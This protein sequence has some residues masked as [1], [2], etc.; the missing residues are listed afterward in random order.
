MAGV[1]K[2]DF[3]IKNLYK[4]TD[5]RDISFNEFNA[6]RAALRLVFQPPLHPAPEPSLT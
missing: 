3:C 2:F 4:L 6:L 1:S 5:H